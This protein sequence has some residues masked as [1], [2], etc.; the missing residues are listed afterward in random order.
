MIAAATTAEDRA[1]VALCGLVGCRVQEAVSAKSA[2]LNPDER[3][4]RIFGKGDVV[5]HVPVS[6]PAWRA[7]GKT[8]GT[9]AAVG[10]RGQ[11]SDAR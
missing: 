7:L 3:E 5:R 9:A 11:A 4:L 6:E 2:D 1:L 8:F 10:H